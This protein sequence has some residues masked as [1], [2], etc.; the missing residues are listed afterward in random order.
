MNIVYSSSDLYAPIMG[1]S[2]YSLLVSN[3]EAEELQVLIID[4][5]ISPENKEKIQNMCAS[6]GR[7]VTFYPIMDIENMTGSSIDVGKW[8]ISTFARL[9]E[10]SLFPESM[11]KVLHIDC[12]TIVQASLQPLW[13][14]ELGNRIVAG[15][16]DCVSAGYREELGLA[17]GD[18]YLNAGNILLNL[19]QIRRL[20]V[21]A[22]FRQYI[23]DHPRLTYVDQAVLNACLSSEEK[24][25]V[26]LKYN[27]YSVLYYVNF[28]NLMH[29][30]KPSVFYGEE[31]VASAKAQPAIVHFTTCFVDGTRPWIE[32]NFHPM[33]DRYLDHKHNSPWRDE[34]L[35]PDTR[36]LPSRLIHRVIRL[37]PE[38]LMARS[39]GLVHGVL[40]PYLN[41]HKK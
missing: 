40:V 41:K 25:V 26:P 7:P 20:D 39:V 37:L 4:N 22:R 10:A 16:T 36:S 1:V 6:F 29:L 18:T 11:K 28:K 9:F 21:E 8:N 12:D 30:R 33:L 35:W 14:L 27:V 19:E 17:P 2:L 3:R 24:L 34:P 15:V 5:R 38:G 32:H 31:E 13:D 23:S